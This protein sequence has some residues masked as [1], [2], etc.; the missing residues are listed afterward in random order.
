M[1]RRLVLGCGR[2]GE[3][4]LGVVSTWGGDLWAVVP[5]GA[6]V[7]EATEVVHGDPADPETY[8]DAADTVL[9]LGDDGDDNLAAARRARESFPD[10][11]I[12]ACTGDGGTPADFEPIVDRVIDPERVV[13]EQFLGSVVGEDAERTCR[14]LNVLRGIDGRLAVVAHDNPDPDAIASAVALAGI[15]RS[16]G[17]EADPCY[18]GEISHQENQAL[19]NLLELD[20]RGL[21]AA[22][23][24]EEYAGVALVDHSRPGVNDGLDP[25]TPIDV[26]IDHHPP[27]APV[28]ATFV[29]LRSDV[30]ATSTLLAEYLERLGVD[31][32]R[33]VATALLYGIRVDTRDFT[34]EAVDTDFEAAVFLTP[35]ADASILERV[36]SPRMSADVLGTLAAAIQNRE[37]RGDV[38]TSG[39]GPIRDRD[40]LAQAADKLLGMEGISV[41]AVYGFLDETVYLS[42][43]TRGAD[44]DLGEVLRDALGSIGSAGGHADM[45][46]A[47]IPLGILG[48]VEEESSESLS[49]IVDEVIAERIFEVLDDPPSSPSFDPTTPDVAFEFPLSEE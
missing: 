5:E 20:L 14:L 26:V 43:R 37:V 6:T 28:D 7:D 13:A 9:V 45:A 8:P 46:G 36:E 48:T 41:A 22:E 49:E 25:E 23:E 15:A 33:E 10:A 21:T 29:D 31:P 11:Q 44:V 27:R 39:V 4:V 38:L 19:V 42:A 12:V 24:I 32:S 47:Q 35:Y 16:I 30:G 2:A 1:V 18:Y 40:A 34:R 3:I 17:V